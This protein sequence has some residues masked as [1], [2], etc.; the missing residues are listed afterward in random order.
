MIPT[1]N[2]ALRALRPAAGAAI[3]SLP[4]QVS[5][6]AVPKINDGGR[7]TVF[8]YHSLFKDVIVFPTIQKRVVYIP[9][10]CFNSGNCVMAGRY[11]Q[12]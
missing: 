6:M 8:K 11:S 4:P 9:A 7:M 12:R 3:E 1:R 5:G 2:S 10:K